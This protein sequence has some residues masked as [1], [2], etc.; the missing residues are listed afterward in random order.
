[1]SL[2]ASRWQESGPVHS[3]EGCNH[4][5]AG[6][7]WRSASL[8]RRQKCFYKVHFYSRII[9]VDAWIQSPSSL[10]HAG[11]WLV[12]DWTLYP[13]PFVAPS[14][15]NLLLGK[16]IKGSPNKDM[17]I[18]FLFLFFCLRLL[19]LDL[20]LFWFESP[21]SSGAYPCRWVF[22]CFMVVSCGGDTQLSVLSSVASSR[23]LWA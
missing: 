12:G 2:S 17:L 9:T 13:W 15:M 3:A 23:A 16:C 20:T 21:V 14:V 5:Q 19:A 1:M 8:Q 11:S 6:S 10:F 22:K 18:F 7:H 4:P